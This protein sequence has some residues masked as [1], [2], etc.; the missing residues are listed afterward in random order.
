MA[1]L[2]RGAPGLAIPALGNGKDM[3]FVQ[4]YLFALS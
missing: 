2:L 1:V 3:I 4:T